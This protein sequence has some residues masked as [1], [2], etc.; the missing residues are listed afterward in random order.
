MLA[1]PTQRAALRPQ[2]DGPH[3]RGG[4]GALR[5]GGRPGGDRARPVDRRAPARRDPQGAARRRPPRD[6]R[7]ADQRARPAGG[8]PAVR[9]P[10]GAQGRGPVGGDHHPQAGRVAG[11]RRPADRAAR[12][13]ADRRQRPPDDLDRP[14]ADRGDGRSAR[15]RPAVAAAH[16]RRRRRAGARRCVA[17]RCATRVA[18]CCSTDVDL[19][20]RAGE[21]VGVAGVAGNGQLELYEVAMGLRQPTSGTVER[22]RPVAEGQPGAARSPPARSGVPEDPVRDSVVPGLSVHSHVGLD[23]LDQV[24]KRLGIDWAKVRRRYRR[25]Q[26]GAASCRPSTASA[27]WR[28]CRA[29]T[30]SGSCWCARSPVRPSS[31]SPPTPAAAWT[32]PRPGEPRSCCSNGGPAGPACC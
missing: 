28:R 10:G 22:R 12:R 11:D 20:V 13:Q 19:E 17:C 23:V 6:P 5:A 32:S 3:D 8:R 25:A 14:G 16:R 27:R 2:G 1:L 18:A 21:V 26:R 7:R 30:S 4:R 24:R 31:S 29:G 15:R 9:R